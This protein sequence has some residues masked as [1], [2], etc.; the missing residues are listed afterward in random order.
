MTNKTCIRCKETKTIDN[1]YKIKQRFDYYCKYCR[2]ATSLISHRSGKKRPQCTVEGCNL[3]NYAI[4]MCKMHYERNRRNGSTQ[5]KNYGR[6]SYGGRKYEDVRRNHL[7]RMF[8]LTIEKYNDMAK[9][10][11]EI[12]G[13]KQLHHKQLHVD[14]D[15]KCC[16][17][18][19][20]KDGTTKYYKT[21][22]LCIRGILCDRCNGN[23][24]LYEKGKLRDDYPDRDKI[25]IYVA[26]Y[27]LLISDRI[28]AYDKK[29][30]NR[31]RQAWKP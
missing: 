9:D 31:Q 1:F 4:G 25:I 11:C 8:G 10:G 23:V 12:C 5:L 17:V 16:P 21:C 18:Q 27:D 26:K 29:Q 19:K 28:E 20:Y 2:N 13:K 14:H 15:H 7:N 3:S 30:G 22:G 6:E 24:G